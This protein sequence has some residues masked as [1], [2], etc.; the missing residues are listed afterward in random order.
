MENTFRLEGSTSAQFVYHHA[1]DHH[2]VTCLASIITIKTGCQ[3]RSVPKLFRFVEW[4]TVRHQLHNFQLYSTCNVEIY[5]WGA[6]WQ[7]LVKR[8]WSFLARFA[9]DQQTPGTHF[10]SINT[11]VLLVSV[12]RSG[13]TIIYIESFVVIVDSSFVLFPIC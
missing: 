9:F 5:N 7:N 10:L 8:R 1:C 4:H 2:P 6:A 13:P 3:V 11:Q 12:C